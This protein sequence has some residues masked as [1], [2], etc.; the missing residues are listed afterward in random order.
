[1]RLLALFLLVFL[2]SCASD[3]PDGKTEAEILYKEALELIDSDRLILATEKLN[4][5]KSQHPYSYYATPAELLMAEVLFK[6]ESYIEAAAAFLLFRDFHPKNEKIAYVVYMIGESYYKQ[7]PDTIDR[8]LESGLEAIKYYQ[9][10]IDKYPGGEFQSKS[11]KRIVKIN[12]MLKSK[13]RYIADFYFRTEVWQAAAYWYSD[14]LER[15][16]DDKSLR[17][18]AMLRIVSSKMELKKWDECLELSQKFSLEVDKKSGKK[19]EKIQKSCEKK[20]IL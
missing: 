11:Q 9:E 5:I 14:I 19:I 7:L 15:H 17:N 4:Q 10:V 3:T 20:E 2:V 16:P 6:Q 8:D 1:M 12:G 13:D 18:E